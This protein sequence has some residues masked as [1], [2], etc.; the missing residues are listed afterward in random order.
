MVI[1]V[2]FMDSCGIFIAILVGLFVGE[3]VGNGFVVL[4][5]Y[6]Y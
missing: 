4:W 5:W 2:G 6:I 3:F 1:L